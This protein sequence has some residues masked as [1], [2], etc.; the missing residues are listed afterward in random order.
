MNCRYSAKETSPGS[1][2]AFRFEAPET[3]LWVPL[4]TL[5]ITRN[6]SYTFLLRPMPSLTEEQL[7]QLIHGQCR[8]KT[9]VCHG[10][11]GKGGGKDGACG[12]G[13]KKCVFV[14]SDEPDIMLPLAKPSAPV[15]ICGEFFFRGEEACNGTCGFAHAKIGPEA[16]I[17]DYQSLVEGVLARATTLNDHRPVWK[18]SKKAKRLFADLRQ[19]AAVAS[20]DAVVPPAAPGKMYRTLSSR[21]LPLARRESNPWSTDSAAELSLDSIWSSVPSADLAPSSSGGDATPWEP[22]DFA[23]L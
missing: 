1:K 16:T 2:A 14:H 17:D 18:A 21:N 11:G 15:V 4:D 12:F 5:P 9:Q 10:G 3:L 7:R 23:A 13:F 8:Y 19:A 20:A 6:H 22:F